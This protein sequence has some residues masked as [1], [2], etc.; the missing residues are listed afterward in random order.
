MSQFDTQVIE[1]NNLTYL[2]ELQAIIAEPSSIDA[3]TDADTPITVGQHLIVPWGEDNNLPNTVM[4]KIG[5]SDPLAANIDHNIKMMYGQGVKPFLSNIVDGVEQLEVCTDERVLAF[6]ENNDI[7]GYFLEQCADMATFYQTYPEVILTRDLSEIYS[8]RHKE[9]SFSRLG[10]ADKKTGEIVKHFYSAAWADGTARLDNT[11]VSEILNRHNPLGDLRNRISKRSY[12][13]PRFMMHIYFPTP[14]RVYYQS[15]SYYSIFRSGSYDYSTM[16]WHFKKALMKNG[17]KTRYIIY[18]SDK[19]WL[20]IFNEEKIDRTNSEKVKERKE[21]EYAKFRNFL[22]NEEN[23]GKGLTVKKTMIPSGNSVVEEKYIVI[24]TVD[25]NIKG[26]EFLEDSSE[27]S[28]SINYATNVHPSLIGSPPGK[29]T[30]SMS[31]TDKREL[32]HIKAAMMAA[33]RDR[34]LRP[35]YLVK[36]FNNFPKNLV[37]KVLDY[38]FTTLDNNKTGKQTGTTGS[39]AQQNTSKQ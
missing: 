12:V 31:G 13:T 36:S 25:S 35:L 2:P 38:E 29:T 3:L 23:A 27:V 19:Y 26:G 39:Q 11:V 10:V 1:I 30:G 4:D 8:L 16:I 24:E 22:S 15:P 34:L 33:Y 17:L 7:P 37:W 5:K 21:A 14:G 6:M 9:A 20:D 28:N 32:F 18:I